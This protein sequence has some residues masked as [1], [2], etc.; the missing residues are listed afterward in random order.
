M[1]QNESVHSCN[2]PQQAL[3]NTNNTSEGSS[4]QQ[5]SPNIFNTN[6]NTQ[7][8]TPPSS[9]DSS[10]VKVGVRVRPMLPKEKLEK[11]RECVTTDP[12]NNQI[13]VGR[14]RTFAFDYVFGQQSQQVS[15]ND[16]RISIKCKLYLA[17]NI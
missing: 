6:G 15:R 13:V 3:L 1:S 2:Q 9:S 11:S 12:V 5:S 16:G 14:D 10:S 4:S 17:T 7:P 8:P